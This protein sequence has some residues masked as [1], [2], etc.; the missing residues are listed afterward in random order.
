M[1]SASGP[2][3]AVVD[4]DTDDPMEEEAVVEAEEA[5]GTVTLVEIAAVTTGNGCETDRFNWPSRSNFP[6]V[7]VW[8]WR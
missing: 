6:V 4:D 1:T 7:P 5:E 3:R 2:D 8:A